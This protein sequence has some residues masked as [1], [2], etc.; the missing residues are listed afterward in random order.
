MCFNAAKSWKLGWY[1]DRA[2][3]ITQE[4]LHVDGFTGKLYAFVDYDKVPQGE[5]VLLKVGTKYLIYNEQKGINAETQEFANTVSITDA[6]TL[7][8]FSDAVA[9]LGQAGQTYEFDNTDG[10][11][12]TIEVCSIEIPENG[13]GIDY[14][15]VS[16]SMST[17]GSTCGSVGVGVVEKDGSGPGTSRTTDLFECILIEIAEEF[18]GQNTEYEHACVAEGDNGE[19]YKRYHI[20]DN[21]SK[22]LPKLKEQDLDLLHHSNQYKVTMTNVVLESDSVVGTTP[23]TEIVVEDMGSDFENNSRRL[24][25]VGIRTIVIVRVTTSDGQVSKTASQIADA[26]FGVGGDSNNLKSRYA[27]CSMDKLTFNPGTGHDFVDGVAEISVSAAAVGANILDFQA[28]ITDA[29]IAKYGSSLRN[30]YN[31][32][33]YSVP[34]G[35]TMGAGGSDRWIAFAYMN[36]YLSVYNDDNIVYISN[37]VHETGHNLGLMHSNHGEQKYGDQSGTMGYGYGK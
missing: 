20:D 7:D 24:K 17:K 4:M 9:A 1:E 26:F 5:Y 16:I 32:V 13:V 12:V 30:T 14:A 18:E 2:L 10:D 37:Q 31:H 6:P 21:N 35:T 29:L 23:G 22:I 36:S 33:V 19:Y 25:S 15:A 3:E 28:K 8:D 27:D 34:K 11:A